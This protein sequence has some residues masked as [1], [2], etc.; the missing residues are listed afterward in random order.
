MSLLVSQEA[1]QHQI[2]EHLH[3]RHHEA[4]AGWRSIRSRH[5]GRHGLPKLRVDM[6]KQGS[7]DAGASRQN[8]SEEGVKRAGGETPARSGCQAHRVIDEL[9][10]PRLAAPLD[11]TGDVLQRLLHGFPHGSWPGQAVFVVLATVTRS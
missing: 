5:S 2:T 9:V 1:D 3:F 4:S 11:D 7:A 6:G 8:L 10:I